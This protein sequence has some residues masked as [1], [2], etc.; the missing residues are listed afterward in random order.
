[1]TLWGVLGELATIGL[2]LYEADHG[3]KLPAGAVVPI[4]IVIGTALVLVSMYGLETVRL[5]L[6]EPKASGARVE[7]FGDELPSARPFNL[8]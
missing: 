7:S 1:V 3:K 5:T 4:W 2:V 8:L 6:T